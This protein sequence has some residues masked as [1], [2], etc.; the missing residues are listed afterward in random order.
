MFRLRLA[1]AD[2]QVAYL[3]IT[4]GLRQCVVQRENAWARPVGF[5]S[6]IGTKSGE[7]QG[8]SYFCD[9]MHRCIVY[10][11]ASVTSPLE[12]PR[13]EFDWDKDSLI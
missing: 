8:Y 9:D 13:E 4:Q 2:R 6:S 10:G 5:K 3:R 7:H 12:F 1:F 11:Q